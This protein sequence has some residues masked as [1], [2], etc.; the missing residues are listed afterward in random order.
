M[1]VNHSKWHVP[2]EK[3]TS[4]SV[5][6]GQKRAAMLSPAPRAM[7]VEEE[8][9]PSE[10]YTD[11]KALQRTWELVGSAATHVLNLKEEMNP[12]SRYFDSRILRNRPVPAEMPIDSASFEV[13]STSSNGLA[14]A[15]KAS[16]E[17][18][19]LDDL[20]KT[21]DTCREQ[22]LQAKLMA[23]QGVE[24]KLTHMENSEAR[25]MAE[26]KGRTMG[27]EKQQTSA[28]GALANAQRSPQKSMKVKWGETIVAEPVTRDSADLVA[29]P[30]Q[31]PATTASDYKSSKNQ[32]GDSKSPQE[33]PASA[34]AAAAVAAVAPAPVATTMP[35]EALSKGPKG[36]PLGPPSPEEIE[37]Q[38]MKKAQALTDRQQAEAE[39]RVQ[40]RV[41]QEAAKKQ[42]EDANRGLPKGEQ[43]DDGQESAKEHAKESALVDQQAPGMAPR[44]SIATRDAEAKLRAL[45]ERAAKRK[46]DRASSSLAT[47]DTKAADSMEDASKATKIVIPKRVLADTEAKN[48]KPTAAAELTPAADSSSKDAET[49]E[50][51]VVA[52]DPA[53]RKSLVDRAK[54]LFG[55]KSATASNP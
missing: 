12:P 34:A 47:K 29:R 14:K 21:F 51:K 13:Q 30:Q 18:D 44:L 46:A 52:E 7:Q 40:Q 8:L 37:A 24:A 10:G 23:L 17:V 2:E 1:L 35:Q 22:A 3:L 50:L 11:S 42:A 15:S 54:G 16:D 41:L 43:A 38:A 39:K 19:R 33:Q 49:A 5:L 31:L 32:T 25:R 20:E 36:M 28:A 48:A 55:R 26:D 53:R 4:L 6:D 45:E 9:P 27:A